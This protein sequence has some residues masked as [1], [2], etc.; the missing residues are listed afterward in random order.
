M[1]CWSNKNQGNN[2]C[3]FTL[4]EVL[5]ALGIVAITLMTAMA[6]TRQ[7]GDGQAALQDRTLADWC[8]DNALISIK[9]RASAPAVGEQNSECTQAGKTWTVVSSTTV[10]PGAPKFRRV[11]VFVYDSPAKATRLAFLTTVLLAQK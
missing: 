11:E 7:L 3:G 1:R 2:S 5:V 10:P 8:A 9:L 4:V 6:L